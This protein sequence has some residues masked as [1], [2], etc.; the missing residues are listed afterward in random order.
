MNIP[1]RSYDRKVYAP[2]GFNSVSAAV[3][4]MSCPQPRNGA[5]RVLVA[6]DHVALAGRI[7][8]RLRDAGLA[9]DVARGGSAALTHA[10]LTA[11]DVIVLDRT[12]QRARSPRSRRRMSP[13][14]SSN[15]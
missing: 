4:P 5:R 3:G 2:A 8:E 9:V 13:N 7:A 6:E 12:C 11:Y 1:I 14:S 10:D 15:Q